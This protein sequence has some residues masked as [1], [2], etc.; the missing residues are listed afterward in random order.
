MKTLDDV[1]SYQNPR[2]VAKIQMLFDVKQNKAEEL[3]QETLK[4]LWLCAK[5]KIDRQAQQAK[6]PPV[7]NVQTGMVMLDEVWHIFILHTRDYADFCNTYLGR[8]I[9]HSPAGAKRYPPTREETEVQLAY[10]YDQL[11]SETLT[12][13]YV[14]Y[15]EAYSLQ[16]IQALR[17]EPLAHLL[18]Q[19]KSQG[20]TV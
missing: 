16:T 12:K 13:W 3:F 1:L 7:L 8:F 10:I 2:V 4:W 9:H 14:T 6:V 11:G 20:V 19:K 18:P 5:A 15:L 17:K